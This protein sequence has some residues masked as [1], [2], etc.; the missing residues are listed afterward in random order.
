M[1]YIA[2]FLPKA[3]AGQQVNQGEY[4]FRVPMEA[5]LDMEAIESYYRNQL[6]SLDWNLEDS[7]WAGMQF[8]KEKSV[9]LVTIAP[10]AN[11]QNWIVTLVYVPWFCGR[12]SARLAEAR[13]QFYEALFQISS[14]L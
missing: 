11:A 2:L 3:V 7:R 1:K 10:T 14:F 12:R 13:W 6:K 4:E 8:T 5:G 9:V